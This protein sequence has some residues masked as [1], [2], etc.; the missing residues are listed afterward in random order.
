[1]GSTGIFQQRM[2]RAWAWTK[3]MEILN[4]IVHFYEIPEA[5]DIK[6]FGEK[7]HYGSLFFQ[8]SSLVL[9]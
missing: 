5:L 2:S 7:N 4:W 8:A 1:M 9:W 3:Q 6:R